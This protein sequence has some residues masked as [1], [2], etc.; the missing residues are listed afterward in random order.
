MAGF[1][2]SSVTVYTAT[3]DNLATFRTTGYFDGLT[4][5][6]NAVDGRYEYENA[7]FAG[8]NLVNLAMGRDV[9][10][11]NFPQQVLAI[12]FDCDLSSASLVVYDESISNI[13]S[14]IASSSVLDV[15]KQQ[16]SKKALGP[17]RAQFVAL[18][19]VYQTGNGNNGLL[20]GYLTVAGRLNLN[21]TNSCPQPVLVLDRDPSD[22]VVPS[23]LD[24]DKGDNSST[25]QAH[26]IGDVMT[27]TG[28]QTQTV[29][30]P[31]GDLSI[32]RELPISIPVETD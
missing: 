11:T 2:I 21:P 28:G 13:V 26:L 19:N 10:D 22:N 15:V 30:L 5:G 4:Q 17:D 3:A 8:H 1:A 6:T 23:R 14:G 12:T 20:G 29:L 31:F 32:R 24:P 7:S 25:G 18:L 9:N 27:V 16:D